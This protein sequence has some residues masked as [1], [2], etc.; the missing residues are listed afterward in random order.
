M[1]STDDDIYE[2]PYIKPEKLGLVQSW[3]R[4][5]WNPETRQVLGRTGKSWG[6]FVLYKLTVYDIKCAHT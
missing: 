4:E 1:T 5:L 2:F 6:E 3:K